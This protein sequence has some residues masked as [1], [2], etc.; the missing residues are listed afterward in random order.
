MEISKLQ[1]GVSL[2]LIL[3]LVVLVLTAGLGAYYF[4]Y[5]RSNS[6]TTPS[7]APVSNNATPL[8]TGYNGPM[9]GEISEFVRAKL[10]LDTSSVI[11]VQK[12]EGDYA[13]GSILEPEEPGSYWAIAKINGEWSYIITVNGTPKCKDVEIF[14]V[15]TFGGIF[16]KG[17]LND[18]ND[19][20][21]RKDN[22]VII[23]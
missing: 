7:P 11:G 6:N 5:V 9:L 3:F 4:Y 18:N 23:E 8:Y 19:Y 22:K 12:V 2:V 14:P 20:F 1:K 21:S 13:L 10:G 16:D 17:C 15:G